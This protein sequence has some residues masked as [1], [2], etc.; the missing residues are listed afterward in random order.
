MVSS[1]LTQGAVSTLGYLFITCILC[2][3]FSCT[4]RSLQLHLL[5]VA[6]GSKLCLDIYTHPSAIS[7]CVSCRSYY[8]RSYAPDDAIRLLIWLNL[9]PVTE[10]ASVCTC[11]L[12]T[13]LELLL[14]GLQLVQQ[15]GDGLHRAPVFLASLRH[16]P[17]VRRLGTKDQ[18]EK[19]GGEGAKQH[20]RQTPRSRKGD[21]TYACECACWCKKVSQGRKVCKTRS[22]LM[23]NTTIHLYSGLHTQQRELV[24]GILIFQ[25]QET[26][27]AAA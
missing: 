23:V 24:A 18:Y 26:N 15:V 4:L 6:S 1:T 14:L 7:L 13:Y 21:C 9:R 20:K 16:F 8:E 3:C 10:C 19:R 11:E 5:S 22:D 2:F 27:G 12:E 25:T 17:Q